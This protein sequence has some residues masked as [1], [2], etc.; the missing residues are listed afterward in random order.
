[1]LG[2]RKGHLK[3]RLE[4]EKLKGQWHLVRMARKPREKQPAWLLFKSDDAAARTADAPDILE[5]MPRIG[6]EPA[7]RWR[8]SPA[9]RT[10]SG[11]SKQGEITRKPASRKRR[12]ASSQSC[13]SAEAKPGELPVLCR[14]LPAF[15]RGEG[16]VRR[17]LAPRDQI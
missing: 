16:A 1:M 12:E 15:D 11:R 17:G 14:T 9:I 7:E 6:C 2:Y 5:E 4:G 10:A 8:R 3:F 13:R